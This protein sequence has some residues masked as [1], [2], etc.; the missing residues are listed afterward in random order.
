MFR[1]LGEAAVK[2]REG[3]ILVY[4]GSYRKDPRAVQSIIFIE[5]LSGD[6]WNV[7]LTLKDGNTES[8]IICKSKIDN[9]WWKKIT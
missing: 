4:D 7:L 3:D 2:L 8:D 9:P 1:E 6:D 5:F